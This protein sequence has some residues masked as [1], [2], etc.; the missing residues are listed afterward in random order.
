MA[1][2]GQYIKIIIKRSSSEREAKEVL[3][4]RGWVQ[5]NDNIPHFANVIKGV[6]SNEG[7]EITMNCNKKA[8][9]WIIE[10]VRVKTDGE[11]EL[12]KAQLAAERGL[13][14]EEKQEI[15]ETTED[16][17]YMKMDGINV[18]NCLNVLVT[19]YFLQLFWVYEKVWQVYFQENFAEVINN[20]SISLSNINPVIVRHVAERIPE[21]CMEQLKEDR[22]DKF[23]SNVYKAKI[24]AEILVV[25]GPESSNQIRQSELQRDSF[26]TGVF[27]PTSSKNKNRPKPV[28]FAEVK[29][30]RRHANELFWCG[31]CKK[32]ITRL[33]AT[34]VSCVKPDGAEDNGK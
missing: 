1:L 33:Q 2:C 27:H 19:S 23:I 18:E 5:K 17:M 29:E 24:D 21:P 3:L 20:C 12:E 4:E 32:L 11:E 6:D 22:K 25:S 14:P 9:E 8:F 30:A 10:F 7:V 13:T 16:K 15:N 31:R 26:L 34:T 28:K